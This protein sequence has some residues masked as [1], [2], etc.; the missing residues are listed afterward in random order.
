[1][2]RQ[3]TKWAY[4]T[5]IEKSCLN[6]P[7]LALLRALCWATNPKTGNTNALTDREL[8]RLTG[9]KSPQKIKTARQSLA[10]KNL[11]KSKEADDADEASSAM[12][13]RRTRKPKSCIY[14]VR[15]E[16]EAV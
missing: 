7:E 1:M 6:P 4:G 3:A 13:T 12:P 14:H 15:F 5:E 16:K 8:G 9:F 11:I 2:S 10:E